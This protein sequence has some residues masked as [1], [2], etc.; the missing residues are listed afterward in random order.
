MSGNKVLCSVVGCLLALAG[1]CGDSG[2]DGGSGTRDPGNQQ[3]PGTP[4]GDT[5]G[6]TPGGDTMGGT[7][8]G[9]TMVGGTPGGDTMVGGTPG[10]DT[11]MNAGTSGGDGGGGTGGSEP[12]PA[13]C[14]GGTPLEGACKETAE[15][16]YA[17]KTEIDVWWQ[18]DVDPPLVDPGRGKIEVYLMGELTDVCEDGSGGTGVMKGC[19]TVLPPFVTYVNCD[20]YQIEFPDE[21]WDSPSMPTFTTTGSTTGFNPGDTLTLAEASGLVGIDL[22]DESGTWPTPADTGSI[23]C[24]AGTGEACFPDHDGDG[25]P[26]ITVRLA[27]LGTNFSTNSCGL[28]TTDPVVYRGAPLDALGALDDN[29]VR[30]ETLFIGV[31]TRLGGAGEIGADCMSGSGPATATS[32]DSRV[33]DCV[34]TD[35]QP[36][37]PAQS[38]F[39]DESAPTYNILDAGEM[40]PS[41]VMASPCE[42]SGGC[43]G[44]AC[45]LDQTPSPGTRSALVRLGDLGGSFSCADVRNATYPAF[46]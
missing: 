1:A 38:Q 46:Q 33:W 16:V 26:G 40:P 23:P 32:L 41:N 5:M 10:G 31:R 25:N 21:L 28:F 35:D 15:G 29:S 45:P 13:M 22:T 27:N 43:A 4:G 6:G 9:D 30:A 3:V 39:V 12:P 11:M 34:R 2:G 44:A 42:C 20:A 14:G 24:A 18:D 19:G 8:G 36:C 7:P 37:A 17:I